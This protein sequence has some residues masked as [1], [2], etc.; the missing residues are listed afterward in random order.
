MLSRMTRVSPGAG[1]FV[2][3]RV[4]AIDGLRV[5]AVLLVFGFHTFLPPLRN[6]GVGV[7]VFF[8]ISGFV[9]TRLLLAERRR[10]GSNRL[11]S[12]YLNRLRR[13]M[14]ALV[15]V[16]AVVA[17]YGVLRDHRQ[18]LPSL[19]A[20]TYTGD[21]WTAAQGP[22][23]GSLLGHT[24]SLAVEEQFYLLWPVILL[25]LLRRREVVLRRV[26]TAL[27]VLPLVERVILV[28]AIDDPASRVYFAPDTRFD[29]LLVG[30]GLALW[31]DRA[32]G[33]RA[34][35]RVLPW[36]AVTGLLAVATVVDQR[37]P[38]A[39]EGVSLT[40]FPTLTAVLAA[41][42]ILS[43]V[44]APAHPLSRLLGLRPL[45]WAGQRL[46]YGFYLWHYP[47][48]VLLQAHTSARKAAVI[49]LPVTVL[50]ALASWWL[51]ERR[52]HKPHDPRG[53]GARVVVAEGI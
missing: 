51:V 21:L 36:V 35:G 22:V 46:S 10:T 39:L 5:V 27:V 20:L 11:R 1:D 29:Q 8:T 2:A 18:L 38:A 53:D 32:R 31:V 16:V 37:H 6:G 13:L 14:P 30:C 25:L 34:P 23:R 42:L 15:A 24:W 47:V 52:F 43:F 40:L 50:A 19:L 7:D 9:I 28:L 45:A 44:T 3:G 48:L 41:T 4:A 33:V 26:V 17:G 12:F 49:G